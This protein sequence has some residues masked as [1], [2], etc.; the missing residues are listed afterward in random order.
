MERCLFNYYI[1]FA[2]H[3]LDKVWSYCSNSDTILLTLN[4]INVVLL[5]RCV[6]PLPP[7]IQG[8]HADVVTVLTRRHANRLS[9]SLR[10]GN[11]V[12]KLLLGDFDALRHGS[13]T[14]REHWAKKVE[15]VC[16]ICTSGN[17]QDKKAEEWVSQN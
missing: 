7:A 12:A 14:H 11:E 6:G 4:V 8:V 9:R 2:N 5:S 1:L 3:T 17:N 13:V 15:R 10:V 16:H